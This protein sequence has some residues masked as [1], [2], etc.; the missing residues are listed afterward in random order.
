MQILEAKS[1]SGSDGCRRT[2][3]MP[4]LFLTLNFQKTASKSSE[5]TERVWK[6]KPRERIEELDGKPL[7]F[8]L[9]NI[10][11]TTAHPRTMEAVTCFSAGFEEFEAA[12]SG[13]CHNLTADAKGGRSTRPRSFQKVTHAGSEWTAFAHVFYSK[14]LRAF[15]ERVGAHRKISGR[16]ENR[17]PVGLPLP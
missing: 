1:V 13:V 17:R 5:I 9:C 2:H 6:P 8:H 3:G 14:E 12:V 15:T 16:A 10:T 11:K 7:D 4:P